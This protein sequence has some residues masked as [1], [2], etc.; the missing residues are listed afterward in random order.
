VLWTCLYNRFFHFQI[1]KISYTCVVFKQNY[2]TRTWFQL[3]L[4]MDFCHDEVHILQQFHK[5][6]QPPL[7]NSY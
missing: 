4:P 7:F 3:K 6:Q 2:Q 5:Q 1:K